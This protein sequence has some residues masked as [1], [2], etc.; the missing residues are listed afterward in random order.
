[1]EQVVVEK[2]ER[3]VWEEIIR[4]NIIANYKRIKGGDI[5]LG[6]FYCDEV[7]AWLG[8]RLADTRL[9]LFRYI[10]LAFGIKKWHEKDWME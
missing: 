10:S 8:G 9:D 5:I 6:V 2:G 7:N 4:P 3:L 1:M